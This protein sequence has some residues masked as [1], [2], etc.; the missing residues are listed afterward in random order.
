MESLTPADIA[1]ETSQVSPS[2][3]SGQL[4]REFDGVEAAL[5]DA[6]QAAALEDDRLM[7]SRSVIDPPAP[8]DASGLQQPRPDALWQSA[9]AHRRQVYL[10][11]SLALCVFAISAGALF[12]FLRS[13]SGDAV[14]VKQD[15]VTPTVNKAA[16][17]ELPES[18]SAIVPPRIRKQQRS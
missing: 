6:S 12:M 15:E 4:T 16:V 7:I 18:D 2:P 1:T 11:S 9:D 5:A 14:G 13:M 3:L 17:P 10:L 8:I